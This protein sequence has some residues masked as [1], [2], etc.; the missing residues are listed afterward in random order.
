MFEEFDKD[1]SGTVS[2]EE[3]KLMLRKLNIPDEEA[4]TL[5]AIHDRNKDGELQYEEFVSFLLHSW[6]I[7]MHHIL[8]FDSSTT[9]LHYGCY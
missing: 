2:V 4:E 5:V 7:F 8:H 3:A 1:G 6:R 9:N